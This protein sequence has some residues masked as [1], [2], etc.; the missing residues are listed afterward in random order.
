M[1]QDEKMRERAK[2]LMGLVLN[3][4]EYLGALDKALT[5]SKP[6]I[7]KTAKM[8]LGHL[9]NVREE[10]QPEMIRAT[11]IHAKETLQS[12]KAYMTA[13]FSSDEA[14]QLVLVNSKQ[15]DPMKFLLVVAN[16][17]I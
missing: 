14:F 17:I 2:E 9:N 7:T 5:A 3:A 10:L 8:I 16:K 13:G 12:Y 15:L 4:D 1:T 11:D 6:A